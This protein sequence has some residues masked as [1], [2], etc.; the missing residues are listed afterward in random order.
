MI[1]SK[2]NANCTWIEMVTMAK[3]YS[4]SIGLQIGYVQTELTEL[5]K[6]LGKGLVQK[7][8]TGTT[9]L[10]GEMAYLQDC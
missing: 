6:K 3:W 5:S 2:K 4:S 10:S 8:N 9:L 7:L 1:S